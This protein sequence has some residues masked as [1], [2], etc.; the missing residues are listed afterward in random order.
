[1]T[2]PGLE[3]DVDGGMKHCTMY[4]GR[5]ERHTQMKRDMCTRE[6]IA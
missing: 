1:M 5:V 3:R 2:N 4:V 6:S